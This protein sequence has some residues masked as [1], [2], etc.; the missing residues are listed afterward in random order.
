MMANTTDTTAGQTA[1]PPSEWIVLHGGKIAAGGWVLDVACGAGRHA[2]WFALRGHPVVA[3]D[4]EVPSA[5]QPGVDF[6]LA[7]LESGPWPLANRNFA[8]IVVTNYLFRPL[9]PRLLAS[10]APGGWLIYET[11]AAGNERY[12]RPTNPDFL[13]QPGELLELVKGKL[14]VAAFEHGYRDAPRP[15]VV[16]CIAACNV[17]QQ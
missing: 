12:G 7:D 17:P 2:N 10:L 1:L 11:F 4:R 3:I 13:L 15:A 14:R 8:G 9:F 16:Q 5:L 6:V